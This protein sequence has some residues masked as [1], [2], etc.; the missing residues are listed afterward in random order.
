MHLP[1]GQGQGLAITV[2]TETPDID[3]TGFLGSNAKLIANPHLL[4]LF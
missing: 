4:R 1:W 3:R 2:I